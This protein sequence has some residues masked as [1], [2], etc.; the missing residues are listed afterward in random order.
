[1]YRTHQIHQNERVLRMLSTLVLIWG[2]YLQIPHHLIV[3]P[4]QLI[5]DQSQLDPRNSK[6]PN[7]VELVC[8]LLETL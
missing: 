5:P 8:F 3:T 6:T 4:F 7:T 1:M 2:T